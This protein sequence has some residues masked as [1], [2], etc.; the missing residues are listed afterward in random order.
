[1]GQI[2]GSGCMLGTAITVFAGATRHEAVDSQDKSLIHSHLVQGKDFL[3]STLAAVLV[4]TIAGQ[5]A[6]ARDDVKGSGTFRSAFIDELGNMTRDHVAKL[7]KMEIVN[8]E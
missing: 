7:A 6:G 5:V 4:Y 3:V 8:V 1:M 2:T